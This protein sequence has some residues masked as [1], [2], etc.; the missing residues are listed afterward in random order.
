MIPSFIQKWLS[1][2]KAK[3]WIIFIGVVGLMLIGLS[4]CVDSSSAVK[5]DSVSVSSEEFTKIL[6]NRLT[7]IISHIDGAGKSQVMVTL[8]NGVQYVYATEQKS[9]SN[10]SEDTGDTSSR[11][12]EQDDLEETV[13]VVDAAEGRE[14]LLVTEME[15]VVKG[16]VVICEGGD[17]EEVRDKITKAV[18][19]AVNITSKRVYVTK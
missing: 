14:G 15:P 11:L 6:E 2:E 9:N 1:A 4:E 8:E 18:M 3:Q 17:R 7:E 12:S 10:R 13:I 5:D 19:T 16:V